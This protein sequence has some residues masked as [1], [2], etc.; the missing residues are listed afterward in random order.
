[1]FSDKDNGLCHRIKIMFH[2]PIFI[3]FIYLWIFGRSIK[4]LLLKEVTEMFRKSH[5]DVLELAETFTNE[6]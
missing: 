2:C 1:M 6:E 3:T 5:N 4:R